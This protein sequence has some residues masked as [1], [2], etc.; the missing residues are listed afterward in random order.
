[1][2]RLARLS[3]TIALVSAFLLVNG[4]PVAAV[5][6]ELYFGYVAGDV[7]WVPT[8]DPSEITSLTLPSGTWLVTVTA[9]VDGAIDET[10]GVGFTGCTL[11]SGSARLDE[12]G[13]K[14]D[15][16][17]NSESVESMFLT[18][19]RSSSSTWTASL[20]CA[21]NQTNNI[22]F[23]DVRISALKG[24]LSGPGG[25]KLRR[26]SDAN[27]NVPGDG[28]FHTIASIDVTAGNWW[29]AAKTSSLNGFGGNNNTVCRIMASSTDK[30]STGD[31]LRYLAEVV[32][33]DHGVYGLP[34]VQVA[35]NFASSATVNFECKGS[36]PF[37]VAV[38][39]IVALKA[40]TLKRTPLGGSTSTSGSGTPTVLTTYQAASLAIPGST[41]YQ[42][43]ASFP[44]PAGK[45]LAEAK[46]TLND[47][48]DIR[49]DCQLLVGEVVGRSSS[50]GGSAGGATGIYMQDAANNSSAS[51]GKLQCK[52]SSAG[53]TLTNLRV[54]LISAS[55]ITF[56]S[57]AV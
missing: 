44:I 25:P 15:A 42:T 56:V 55:S 41:T 17:T 6:N 40:G 18:A 33:D 22:R 36:K 28:R 52:G 2:R 3:T 48:S 24:V 14:L 21:S 29:L 45:W 1:V 30:D 4:G 37:G 9:T 13:W 5:N 50:F 38:T 20:K 32:N 11:F 23:R 54:T 53:T 49:V 51:T 43:L 26:A 46:A 39:K 35:H 16:N 12:A 10:T 31:G 47:S 8:A 34:A 7:V 19:V 57:T 27:A